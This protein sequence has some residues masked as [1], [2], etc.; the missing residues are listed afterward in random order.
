MPRCALER[1]V[2]LGAGGGDGGGGAGGA[3]GGAV[4]PYAVL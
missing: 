2:L 4:P 3:K 1:S